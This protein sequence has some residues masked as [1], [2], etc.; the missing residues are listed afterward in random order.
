MGTRQEPIEEMATPG[1][2]SE[3]LPGLEA[4][5]D[6][7]RGAP[8]VYR[9]SRFWEHLAELQYRELADEG[10]FGAFKRTVN[11]HFFQFMVTGVRDPQF[12][13]VARHWLLRPSLRALF[14]RLGGPLPAPPDSCSPLRRHI[15]GRVYAVYLAMLAQYT[16][17]RDRRG[18]FAELEEPELGRPTCVSY[19]GRAVSEDLCNSVL[20][21]TS[22]LDALPSPPR[23]VVELGSGYGRLAWVF[24]REQ[25]D[26]RY[27]LV[28]IPPGLAIAQRYLTELFPER[29]AFRFRRFDSYAEVADEL[30]RA[31]I[32][33]LTPNQLEMIP[34]LNA[35]LMINVSS[36][37]EM[38]REQIQHYFE[39]FAEHCG[40]FFYSKQW[41]R[42]VNP[43]DGL[44][45]SREDYPVPPEWATVFDRVH[46]VQTRFFE[47]LYATGHHEQVLPPQP[48]PPERRLGRSTRGRTR[49]RRG[50]LTGTR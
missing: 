16:A 33:F 5:L 9:P 27:V 46:P 28:D 24:L 37:H 43:F 25:P 35:D 7:L 49:R 26:V 20:E 15:A 30:E 44:V 14:T 39:L 29:P 3:E 47:A 11:R 50:A 12:R 13:A 31:Q 22:I 40:G 10:G 1:G 17:S 23:V 8:E 32:A 6:E 34:S 4:M 19:E 2:T 21:Y 45:V 42:S 41:Q 38:S 18:V 36:L 48:Q